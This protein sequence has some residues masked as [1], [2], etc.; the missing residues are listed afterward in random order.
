[1]AEPLSLVA[2]IIVVTNIGV[3]VA[4]GLRNLA[5]EIGAA[6]T[7]IRSYAGE[8]LDLTR[9]LKQVQ[10]VVPQLSGG[11]A[12]VFDYSSSERC[13]TSATCFC[14]RWGGWSKP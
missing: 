14:N 9:V 5:D 2:S 7:E 3:G 4:N 10:I 11:A 12:M 1:M 8:V 13:W 6:G